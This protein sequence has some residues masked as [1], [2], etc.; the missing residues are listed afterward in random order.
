M[1]KISKNKTQNN[2]NK[3]LLFP[4]KIKIIS[5]MTRGARIMKVISSP[6]K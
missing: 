4:H 6:E 3:F 2:K 5:N 1:E